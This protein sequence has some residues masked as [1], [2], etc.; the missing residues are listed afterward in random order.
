MFLG[1]M[2]KVMRREPANMLWG[3]LHVRH[4]QG[5]TGQIGQDRGWLEDRTEAQI[6]RQDLKEFRQEELEKRGCRAQSE[7]REQSTI[8]QG[9]RQCPGPLER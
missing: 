9:R 8:T 3:C 2:N 6:V 4:I 5:A 1:R 7:P